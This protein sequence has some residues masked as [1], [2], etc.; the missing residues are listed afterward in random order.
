MKMRAASGITPPGPCSTGSASTAICRPPEAGWG[1]LVNAGQPV[2][3]VLGLSRPAHTVRRESRLRRRSPTR[4]RP[5]HKAA[6]RTAQHLTYHRNVARDARSIKVWA[7]SVRARDDHQQRRA[8]DPVSIRAAMV[9]HC[10]PTG[11]P[12]A[13]PTGH[14]KMR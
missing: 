9:C 12:S 1:W 10:G 6:Q 3:E 8:A 7:E 11:K 2:V 5:Q 4:R 14:F 13:L